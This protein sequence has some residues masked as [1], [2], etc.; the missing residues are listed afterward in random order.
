MSSTWK[1][2]SSEFKANG[3]SESE[4]L[5]RFAPGKDMPFHRILGIRGVA[6]TKANTRKTSCNTK[7]SR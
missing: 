3:G 2:A 6:R 4:T 7:A 5:W 1:S